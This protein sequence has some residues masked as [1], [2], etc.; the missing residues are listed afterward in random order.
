MA[1]FRYPVSSGLLVYLLLETLEFFGFPIFWQSTYIW[2]RLFQKRVV[3]TNLDIYVLINVEIL[4][5]SVIFKRLHCQECYESISELC[6][7]TGIYGV[8]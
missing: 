1:D 6:M 7:D 3:C 5:C 2:W 8:L 4:I